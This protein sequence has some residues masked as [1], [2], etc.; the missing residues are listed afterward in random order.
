MDIK[1]N[2]RVYFQNYYHVIYFYAYFTAFS[3]I[4]VCL[5]EIVNDGQG[6]KKKGRIQKYIVIQNASEPN[7]IKFIKLNKKRG[8][9]CKYV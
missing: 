2:L 6:N 3:T 9:K 5:V 4:I 7:R 8:L 1:L